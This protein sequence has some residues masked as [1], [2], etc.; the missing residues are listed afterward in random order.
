MADSA[1]TK[2]L[3]NSIY[4][5]FKDVGDNGAP[6]NP[7]ALQLRAQIAYDALREQEKVYP[8]EEDCPHA[9]PFRFC[10]GCKVSPCPIGLDTVNR[11]GR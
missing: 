1:R 7:E 10:D 2:R 11:R 4:D 8:P 9:A 3:I 6:V 5:A